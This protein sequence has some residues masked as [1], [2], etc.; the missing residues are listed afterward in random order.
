MAPSGR[1]T[2]QR[3]TQHREWRRVICPGPM[4]RARLGPGDLVLCPGTLPRAPFRERA[5]AA[6]A[7]GFAGI[8]LWMPHRK[9]AHA[10]GLSDA[11]LR[12]ILADHGLAVSDVE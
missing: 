12:A 7:G 10:E 4:A 8:G 2:P 3:G 11:D 6:R 9:H 1:H 5:A